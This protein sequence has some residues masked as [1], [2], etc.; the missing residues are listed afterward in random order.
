[1]MKKLISTLLIVVF[2]LTS[3]GF[4]AFAAEDYTVQYLGDGFI[5]VHLINQTFVENT[6]RTFKVNIAEDGDYA[7]F[8][9]NPNLVS[10]RFAVTFTKDGKTVT[11]VNR[12][13]TGTYAYSRLG[14]QPSGG[15]VSSFALTKGEWTF[16]VDA[17]DSEIPYIDIRQTTIM[18]D[19]SKQA[20]Y[21]MDVNSADSILSFHE[22]ISIAPGKRYEKAPSDYAYYGNLEDSALAEPKTN[23]GAIRVTNGLTAT[24]KVNAKKAGEYKI[25]GYGNFNVSSAN[26]N[27]T[28]D[29]T[30]T[31]NM[32]V[33]SNE[34]ATGS[35]KYSKGVAG[36]SSFVSVETTVNLPAGI[37]SIVFSNPNTDSAKA[38][39]YVDYILVE[40]VNIEE[41]EHPEQPE[42]PE[43]PGDTPEVPAGDFPLNRNSSYLTAGMTAQLTADAD[44]VSW[45]TSN[46]TV[47]TVNDRGLVTAV[48]LGEADIT[49]TTSDGKTAV[50]RVTVYDNS[51]RNHKTI[52]TPDLNSGQFLTDIFGK[53]NFRLMLTFDGTAEDITGNINTTVKDGLVYENGFHG[54]AANFTDGYVE[55]T[56]TSLGKGSMTISTWLKPHSVGSYKEYIISTTPLNTG[57]YNYSGFYISLTNDCVDFFYTIK[58]K[59]R[60]TITLTKGTEAPTDIYDGWVN[61]TYV[62]DRENSKFD[63]YID[64]EQVYTWSMNANAV[65]DGEW[66]PMLGRGKTKNGDVYKYDGLMDDFFIYDGAMTS[67]DIEK[68]KNY[69]KPG[70]AIPTEG[71]ALDTKELSLDINELVTLGKTITPIDAS[72]RDVIWTTSNPSVAVVSDSGKVRGI[73]QGTATITA[74]TLDGG[75]ADSCQVVVSNEE[76]SSFKYDRVCI[77]GVDGAGAWLDEEYMPNVR[78]I[79]TPYATTNTCLTGLP[80]VSGPGWTSIL[81]GTSFD[82]HRITN[83]I[84]GGIPFPLD[85]PYPSIYRILSEADPDATMAY[86]GEYTAV[87]RGMIEPNLNVTMKYD[88][89][90]GSHNSALEY[91]ENN[92]PDLLF[93]LYGDTDH[94]G[95]QYGYGPNSPEHVDMMSQR[96]V[97]IKEIYEAYEKKGLLDTTL[98]ILC[99]DHGGKGKYHGDDTPEERNTFLGLHGYSVQKNSEM[100]ESCQWD[101]AAIAAYA[102][103]LER[104]A[105]WIGKVPDGAFV[106][107]SGDVRNEV[108]LPS[109][110]HRDHINTKTPEEGEHLTDIFGEDKFEFLL[111]F[112]G[113]AKDVT[114]NHEVTVNESVTYEEGYFGKSANFSQGSVTLDQVD[115]EGSDLTI[116]AWIRTDGI[117]NEQILMSS[118]NE[119]STDGD[120]FYFELEEKFATFVINNAN[121]TQNRN[122]GQNYYP[123]DATDGWMHVML[124][125][126]GKNNQIKFYTD[127]EIN[128]GGDY[129]VD[130]T[131]NGAPITIGSTNTASHPYSLTA[132]LD[133][134]F[135]Y[136]GAMTDTDI[137][138]L[139]AYYQRQGAQIHITDVQFND[140]VSFDYTVDGDASDSTLYAAIYDENMKLIAVKKMPTNNSGGYGIENASDAKHLKVFVIDKDLAP[141]CA[142]AEATKN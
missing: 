79:F 100:G 133:D 131:I 6:T 30:E 135:I 141:K 9:A 102:L 74:K 61:L 127:F 128:N 28:E 58:D 109:A 67:S 88:T 82:Y 53:E 31:I 71:I 15:V 29:E 23:H 115:I 17:T 12:V 39:W 138:K 33:G 57:T 75:F 20:I 118:K 140:T 104:P 134:V 27:K 48:A 56:D 13:R 86:F 111:E 1:M 43:Q 107:V 62:F 83:Y 38:D 68:L 120:G 35:Y 46:E 2:M 41:P 95:H 65:W 93:L 90:E 69:Y 59:Y 19:G 110:S 7:M 26:A 124:V 97:Y 142:H 14:V 89:D 116:G 21:P 101:V 24:F 18:L 91:L 63:I 4:T 121:G 70:K 3:L 16:S 47:A 98:F 42:Q 44:N 125:L 50:C 78:S 81:H 106:G 76:T 8:V 34:A 5:R 10:T 112:D 126:D 55:L 60:K 66:T 54:K 117:S 80:S 96:D 105:G 40:G 85:S 37:T 113:E 114:G 99:T 130:C 73:A 64:Y 87:I 32:I 36:W 84:A 139:Q 132:S 123:A 77:I 72:V 122:L 108:P 136:K 22:Y 51:V 11:A 129:V 94:I 137:A 49:A 92:D 45:S 119:M 52:P 103:G 25:I